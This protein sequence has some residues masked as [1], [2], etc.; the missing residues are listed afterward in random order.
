MLD[1]ELR[2]K[3]ALVT[4]AASGIG[5]AIAVALGE[6]GA[7]LS[8]VD[9]H[10][11][12]DTL[13]RLPGAAAETAHTVRADLSAEA[14]CDDAVREAEDRHGPVELLVSAAGIAEHELTTEL[15]ATAW[16][17]T[18]SVNVEAAVWLSRAVAGPMGERGR[19]SVLFVG[20]TTLH[21]TEPAESAYRAS[22]AAL[23]AFM[24]VLAV[25]TAPHGVRVNML[26]PGH[27]ETPLT[28]GLD[29]AATRRVR[30]ATPLGRSGQPPEL[31]ATA[32]LLLSDALSPFTTGAEMLVDGGL[33]LRPM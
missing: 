9:R 8:L 25:E 32:V 22:K 2:G 19:G 15:T 13:G 5:Q 21:H 33:H 3:H 31:A 6:S 1:P 27:F 20:S 11:C 30:D 16:R 18:F 4:G 24:E 14:A 23:R 10:A 26:T 12:D 17:R 7:R 28:R 29:P